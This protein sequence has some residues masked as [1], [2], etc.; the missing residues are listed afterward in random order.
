MTADP[1]APGADAVYLNVIETADRDVDFESYYARIKVLTE[2]GKELGTVEL[3]YAKHVYSVA[4]IK[5]RTIQPD[6]TIIPL[7]GKPADILKE[8]TKGY[9]V[10]RKVFTLPGVQVGSILEYYF[11]LRYSVNYVVN[12]YWFIQHPHFV[13]KAQYKCTSCDYEQRFSVLPPGVAIGKDH[14]GHTILDLTDVPAAPN[15]EW[16]PPMGDMLYKV[17]FFRPLETYGKPFWTY[18]GDS[19]SASV[20]AFVDPSNSL[21][22]AV[23]GLIHPGDTDLD[24]AEKLYKA[25]Q[26]LENTDFTR[27]KSDAERKKLNIQESN[28]AEDVWAHKSGTRTEIALLYLS[29]LRAAGVTAY[30]M[31]VVDRDQG[32][33]IQEFHDY[34]QLDDTLVLVTIDGKTIALDPGQKMCPFQIVSWRH[35]M[36]TGLRQTAS[37]S[38]LATTPGQA[39]TANTIQRTGEITIDPQGAID[40]NLHFLMTGQEALDWRQY[41]LENDDAEVKKNFDEWLAKMVPDGV[42]AHIDQFTGLNDPESDLSAAITVK[43]TLGT[44]TPKRLLLP[45]LFFA[46]H[47]DHPFVNQE[48]RITPVDMHY[49]G[50]TFDTVTYLLPPGFNVESS[51]NPVKVPWQGHAVLNI[52]FKVD[53]GKITVVRKFTRAFT[54]VNQDEYPALHDFYQKVATADQQQLVLTTSPAAKGN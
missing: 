9:Q 22:I 49:G 30:A 10:G 46:A 40:G 28:R 3:P 4:D 23:Q 1:K 19:W 48:K 45:A 13:H 21:R 33:F 16:M 8:K 44:A 51:P 17:V 18:E 38:A 25:V 29:M 36:T 12:P 20:N 5:A 34:D 37:G 2:K 24:K 27:E 41:A 15:E 31:R 53:P 32:V 26:A 6:G 43:G 39:Y 52:D 11:Q 14:L 35:S 54:F 47:G 7:E 42:E 50:Q